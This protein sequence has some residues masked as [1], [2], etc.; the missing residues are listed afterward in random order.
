MPQLK[1]LS[2]LKEQERYVFRYE[3]GGEEELLDSFVDL[4]N[5]RDNN[6]DWFDAAILSFQLSKH[7]V[8][9]A[10]KLLGSE[11]PSVWLGEETESDSPWNMQ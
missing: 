11:G 9:E 1:E 8:E 2:L 3:P 4:A 5:K 6:F 10:D 7:L